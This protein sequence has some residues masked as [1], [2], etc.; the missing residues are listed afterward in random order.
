[1]RTYDRGDT[2]F[3]TEIPTLTSDNSRPF[4]EY[5]HGSLRPEHK[6]VEVD[7]SQ[8]RSVDSEGVGALFSVHKAICTRGGRV[9]LLKPSPLVAGLFTVLKLDHIFEIIPR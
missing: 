9:R 4:K 6:Y 7:L 8:A 2:L 3:I 1:M 5:A